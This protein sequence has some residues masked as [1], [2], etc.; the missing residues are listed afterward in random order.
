MGSQW[1]QVPVVE[2]PGRCV[3]VPHR[4]E[5]LLLVWAAGPTRTVRCPGATAESA[6]RG[7]AEADAYLAA[8]GIPAVPEG[9][10]WFLL[11]PERYQSVEGFRTRL[12]RLIREGKAGAGLGGADAAAGL[13]PVFVEALAAMYAGWSADTPENV[14]TLP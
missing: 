6:G 13:L 10:L 8:A 11:V 12:A 2:A 9:Y 5:S 3:Q 4:G 1:D 7:R 14:L